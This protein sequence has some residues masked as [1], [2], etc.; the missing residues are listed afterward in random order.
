MTALHSLS[1]LEAREGLA[2]G[3]YSSVELC[4]AFLERIERLNP[5]LNSYLHIAAEEALAGAKRADALRAEEGGNKADLPPLLGLP[6]AVK[7]VLTVKGMPATSGSRILESFVPTYDAS[8]VAK[9]KAAGMIVLGKTNTDEFAMGSSTENS[10][11]ETTRNPWDLERVP[12]GSSGGSA[13]AVMAG[14]APIALGTDTGG[15]VRQPAA[16]CGVTGLKPSYSRSSRYGLIAFGSSLDV[17]GILSGSVAE[18]TPLFTAMAGYDPEDATTS[19]RPVPEIDLSGAESLKGMKIGVP[20]EYF[21]EGLQSE[22]EAAVRAAIEAMAE[23]GAEIVE[24][25][26][27]HT[28]YAL[29]VY[30]II[31]P[32]EASANLARFDGVRYGLRVEDE[33]L[34]QMFKHTRGEGF[35]PEVKRRIMIGTH[36]LSTGYYDAF[37]GQ[38]QKVRTLI[39]R[40]FDEAFEGVDLI[41]TPAT[42]TTAFKIGQHS[43]PLEM[44]LQDVFTLPAS[45]AGIPGV[46]MP[47]GFDGKGLPIGM[48]LFAPYFEEARLLRSAHAYQLKTDWHRHRPEL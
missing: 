42:P 34:I 33:D 15:S 24:I 10:A 31:G 25:S 14:L 19:R 7:D 32:A 12:G 39:R 22:V 4:Q 35:G 13:A 28:E 44:Y 26:L 2:K 37:Y 23:L 30:Y 6:L 1:L 8:V 16:L 5:Q 45:L 9:L 47:V 46:S 43:D 40:D 29:P 48:Q 3:D 38:A 36:A 27:P 11:F 20:K 21:I 41:A 18:L 17:V